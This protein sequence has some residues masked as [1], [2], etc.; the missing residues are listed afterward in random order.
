VVMVLTTAD[1]GATAAD[2]G[3]CSLAPLEL[4]I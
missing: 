1:G 3:T 2:A 4:D